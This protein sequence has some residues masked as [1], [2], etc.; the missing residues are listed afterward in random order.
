MKLASLQIHHVA[1]LCVNEAEHNIFMNHSSQYVATTVRTNDADGGGSSKDGK[2]VDTS[3]FSGTEKPY[4]TE[5]YPDVLSYEGRDSHNSLDRQSVRE[6]KLMPCVATKMLLR[7]KEEVDPPEITIHGRV[8]EIDGE[9]AA[10]KISEEEEEAEA[11]AAGHRRTQ[12]T[13]T[14]RTQIKYHS[15]SSSVPVEYEQGTEVMQQRIKSRPGS[16]GAS[17]TGSAGKRP[18]RR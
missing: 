12:S 11:E 13:K 18:P 5:H 6:L 15:R 8:I 4:R 16:P 2:E 14:S 10:V 17:S 7:S 1:R 9:K 3:I